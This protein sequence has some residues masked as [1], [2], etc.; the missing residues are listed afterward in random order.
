MGEKKQ[1]K[2]WLVIVAG[3]LIFAVFIAFLGIRFRYGG[4]KTDF[5]D[6]T[7]A[8]VFSADILETVVNLSDPPGNLAVSQDGRIFFSLHPEGRPKIKVAELVNGKAKPYPSMEFQGPGNTG[9]F[10][11]TVLSVR[12]DSRNRLWTLDLANHGMGQPRLLAFDLA[13]D[14]VV[15]RFDFT[16][17]LA[18]FGSHLNDF[19]INPA[20]DTIFI[21]DASIFAK[22]P[23]I[24]VYDINR[25]KC[26]RM[27]EKHPAVMPEPYIPVVQGRKMQVFGIFAVRPGVDSIALDKS[28]NWLYFAPV[29]NNYMYRIRAEYLKDESLTE[30][31]L[32]DRVEEFALKTMSDGLTMD[33]EDNI[34]IT[35]PEH[36]AIVRLTPD[37][38]LE[39]LVKDHRLRWPDGLGY[40]PDGWLYITCSALHQVIGMTPGSISSKAPFQIYR[41]KPGVPGVAGQ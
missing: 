18:G 21:A 7:T 16:D 9:V 13:T 23:A 15:H 4:G 1:A 32:A 10:F 28:G 25:K 35:D 5:P 38:R 19:Q 31:D 12:I 8:P 17:D 33:L 22:S 40:G 14:Q 29:T 27:L 34:Y 26:R 36:S 30:A 39:T 24:L 6:R 11:D 2:R 3:M 20:G 41:F 37:G